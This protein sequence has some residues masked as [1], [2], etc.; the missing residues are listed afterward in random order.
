MANTNSPFGLSVR[1][2]QNNATPS[3]QLERAQFAADNTQVCGRGDGLQA[4]TT[5]YLSAITGVVVAAK[6]VG[7]AMG[8]EY[9][10]TAVNRRVV[11]PYWPGGGNSGVINV[12]Y[13]PLNIYPSVQ[14]VAQAAGTPFTRAMIGNNM[15]IAYTAPSASLRGGSSLVAITASDSAGAAT[16]PWRLKALWSS[17]TPSGQPGT[18]DTGSYNWG[19]FEFNTASLQGSTA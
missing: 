3:F 7:I 19:I 8:F 17:V 15:E 12:L 11:T 2:V 6:W 1:G 4:L 9:L 16:L 18:D 13:V 10:N 5:G 14:I